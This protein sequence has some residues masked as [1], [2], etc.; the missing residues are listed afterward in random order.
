MHDGLLGSETDAVVLCTILLTL[1]DV[2]VVVEFPD[3][4]AYVLPMLSLHPI[5]DFTTTGFFR[6]HERGNFSIERIG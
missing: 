1:V 6:A 3:H 2:V 5:H 4:I